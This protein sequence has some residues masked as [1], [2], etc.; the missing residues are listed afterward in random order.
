KQI[1]EWMRSKIRCRI[2]KQWKKIK[3][4]CKNLIKL[5]MSDNEAYRN[6]NTRKGYWRLVHSPVLS[7]TLTNDYIKSKNY[8]FFTD[9]YKQV[10][11]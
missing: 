8:I 1:D 2:W 5:G 7:K 10:K 4:R 9:Y 3:T 6:A 11:C